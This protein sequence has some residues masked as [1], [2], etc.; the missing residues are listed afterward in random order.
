MNLEEICNWIV[1]FSAV[2][3]AITNILKFFGKPIKIV[4]KR[5]DEEIEKKIENF[6]DIRLPVYFDERDKTTREKYLAQRLSYLN[7]IQAEVTKNVSLPIE[8]IKELLVQQQQALKTLQQGTKDVL[9]QKIM[10]I[11]HTYKIDRKIPIYVKE[12][13]DELYKD[14]KQEGGNSYI[15]KYYKRMCSWEIDYS[16]DDNEDEG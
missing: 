4:K 12:K 8:E 16:E 2:I 15:D 11:Y 5:Q 9:R 10:D 13:L 7:E 3:L 14:Y 6:L 1:L